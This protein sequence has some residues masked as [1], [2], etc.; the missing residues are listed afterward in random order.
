MRTPSI[1]SAGG[2]SFE[3][4]HVERSGQGSG[5]RGQGSGVGNPAVARMNVP[6][7]SPFLRELEC[8]TM[9]GAV[10]PEDREQ[11]DAYLC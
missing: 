2:L 11:L 4:E 3:C 1:I 7:N 6:A 10:G 9:S 5:K 8:E